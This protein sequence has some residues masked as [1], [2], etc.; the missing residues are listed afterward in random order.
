M[1]KFNKIQGITSILYRGYYFFLKWFVLKPLVKLGY[2]INGKIIGDVKWYQR[3]YTTP[4]RWVWLNNVSYKL[5]KY[6]LF[7]G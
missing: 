7:Q 5:T 6:V 2:I 4:V 3:H 1:N